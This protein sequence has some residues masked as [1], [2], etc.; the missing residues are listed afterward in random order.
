MS[1]ATAAPGLRRITIH[2]QRRTSDDPV[3]DYE[4]PELSSRAGSC[5]EPMFRYAWPRP[6]RRRRRAAEVDAAIS[7]I[8]SWALFGLVGAAWRPSQGAR[9]RAGT[10]AIRTLAHPQEASGASLTAAIGTQNISPTVSGIREGG[11]EGFLPRRLDRFSHTCRICTQNTIAGRLLPRTGNAVPCAVVPMT[12]SG[13]DHL[14]DRRSTPAGPILW[15]RV[16][17]ECAALIHRRYVTAVV[18]SVGRPGE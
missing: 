18:G 4:P 1:Q 13:G 7:G 9:Q 5:G 2:N 14:A 11:E 6:R 15:H 10:G 12:G 3:A 16:L 17:G 8:R